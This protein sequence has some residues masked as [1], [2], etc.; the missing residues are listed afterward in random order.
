MRIVGILVAALALWTGCYLTGIS[1]W[2]GTA[3]MNR[4]S[5][6]AGNITI[7]GENRMG[8]ELGFSDFVFF[9]GQELVVAYDAE[10][11]TGSLWFH[12]FQPFDG[13]IGDGATHYVTESGQGEWTTRIPRTGYYHVTVEP[14]VLHGK[15]RGYDLSYSAWWGA[16]FTEE[17]ALW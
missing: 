3:W 1:P 8:T 6:G 5:F 16:R 2:I 4:S 15:G 9:E 14:S 10:I 11:E 17:N 7:V 13:T 12:V